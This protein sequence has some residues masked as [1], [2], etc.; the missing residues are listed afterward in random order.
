MISYIVTNLIIDSVIFNACQ[1]SLLIN[2]I[3]RYPSLSRA[4]DRLADDNIAVSRR[5]LPK[6]FA[7]STCRPRYILTDGLA[8]E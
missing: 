2:K 4:K 8:R 5:F 6:D 3:Y 7:V 1:C